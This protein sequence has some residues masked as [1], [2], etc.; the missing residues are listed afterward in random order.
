VLLED[1]SYA[2][3]VAGVGVRG[4]DLFAGRMPEEPDEVIALMSYPG[5]APVFTHDRPGE[6]NYER[7]RAQVMV[8]SRY[9]ANAEAKAQAILVALSAIVEQEIQ[10]TR[11]LRVIPL[12]SPFVAGRDNNDRTLIACNYRAM[13]VPG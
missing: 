13:K 8:R 9:R 6:I 2:I 7:P 5:E 1:L 12:Q 10:G 11:Y 4:Q 3:E